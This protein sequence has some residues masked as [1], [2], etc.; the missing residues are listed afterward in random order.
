MFAQTNT[1]EDVDETSVEKSDWVFYEIDDHIQNVQCIT[2]CSNVEIEF[3]NIQYVSS[4]TSILCFFLE[5]TESF[6]QSK[7]E[8][9][10]F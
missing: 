1:V 3:C 5:A 9:W 2:L 7:Y 6:F 8:K 10:E 4:H